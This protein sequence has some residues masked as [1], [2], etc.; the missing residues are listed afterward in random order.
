MGN[1]VTTAA[2]QLPAKLD[3]KAPAATKL[4]QGHVFVPPSPGART[5]PIVVCNGGGEYGLQVPHE[6][7]TI[8]LRF[9]LP[10]VANSGQAYPCQLGSPNTNWLGRN[11]ATLQAT[12]YTTAGTPPGYAVAVQPETVAGQPGYKAT[13]YCPGLGGKPAYIRVQVLDGAN[14]G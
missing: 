3:T 12:I 2:K 4:P 6:G 11:G 10:H 5:L 1:N 14:H 8:V 13:A 9:R 7:G